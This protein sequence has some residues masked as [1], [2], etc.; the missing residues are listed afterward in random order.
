MAMSKG[1]ITIAADGSASGSGL[2]KELYDVHLPKVDFG[3]L[4]GAATVTAKRQIADL[5]T[6]VSEVVTHIV[7]NGKA[8]VDVADAGLQR[9][10]AAPMT[11]DQEC[12]APAAKKTLALE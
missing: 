1:T 12:K 5:L 9:L 8:V 6:T 10:P 3:G 4:T 11:E 7:A 2:A